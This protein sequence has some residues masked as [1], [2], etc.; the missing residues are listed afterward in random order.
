MAEKPGWSGVA[1]GAQ[2][3][4]R[5]HNGVARGLPGMEQ[6]QAGSSN[7]PHSRCWPVVWKRHVCGSLCVC[8]AH[9]EGGVGRGE[10]VS[11]SCHPP[12]RSPDQIGADSGGY[13][14]RLCMSL[15]GFDQSLSSCLC[16]CHRDKGEH[17]TLCL[18]VSFPFMSTSSFGLLYYF[19]Y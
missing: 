18:F 17:G 9:P 5:Q 2:R 8:G 4:R 15:S 12:R 11:L 10:C 6:S 3:V 1:E 19:Y 16:V 7:S 14:I 13:S